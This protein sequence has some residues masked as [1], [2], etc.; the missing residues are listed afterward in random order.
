MKEFNFKLESKD[1]IKMEIEE[2]A[3]NYYGDGID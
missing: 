1:E 3:F 2:S